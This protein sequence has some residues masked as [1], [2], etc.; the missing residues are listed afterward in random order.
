MIVIDSSA[1]VAVLVGAPD[2]GQLLARFGGE[3]LHAPVLIDYEVI[4]AARRMA[5]DQ[6]L[7]EERTLDLLADLDDAPI[8]R[9]PPSDA[10]RRRAYDLRHA[11]SACD[12]SY[13]ALAEALE[14]PLVTRDARLARAHGHGASIEFH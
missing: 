13:V 10:L 14:C 9:W 8:V 11:I 1:L 5:Y 6:R 7:S 2:A 3:E 4:S 12:A